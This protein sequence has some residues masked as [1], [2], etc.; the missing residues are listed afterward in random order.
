MKRWLRSNRGRLATVR[1]CIALTS[2]FVIG[3]L[4]SSAKCSALGISVNVV[5][6]VA[7]TVTSGRITA[8]NHQLIVS[9]STAEAPGGYHVTM[10]ANSTTL[11]NDDVAGARFES[12]ANQLANPGV[13]SVGTW[14]YA[15][16][17]RPG[18]DRNYVMN[19]ALSSVWA[20]VPLGREDPIM[21][22]VLP[23]DQGGLATGNVWFGIYSSN[24]QI[25]GKYSATV[26][27]TVVADVLEPP[28]VES[29]TP[30]A[31]NL[32][33]TAIANRVTITGQYLGT[34]NQVCVDLNRN[35]RCDSYSSGGLW[36]D[37]TLNEIG[38]QVGDLTNTSITFDLPNETDI[39]IGTYDIIVRT[40]ASGGGTNILQ[41]A[42]TYTRTP[43]LVSAT[44]QSF[45]LGG[46]SIM[47]MA[48]GEHHSIVLTKS[49]AVFTYGEDNSYGQLGTG[50]TTPH[51]T[52]TNITGSF[53]GKVVQIAALGDHSLVLTEDGRVYSWGDNEYGQVGNGTIGRSN[54]ALS[55]VDI[56]G[57]FNL[58]AGQKIIEIYA[59]W[60][61]S[62]ALTDN[63][64]VFAW[65]DNHS[66]QLATGDTEDKAVPTEVTF[67]FDGQMITLA[68]DSHVL[69]LTDTGH[70]YSWGYNDHGQADGTGE[71]PG[72]GEDMSVMRPIEITDKLELS[73]DVTIK[74]IGAGSN[75]SL[76]LLSDNSA[77]VWGQNDYGSLGTGGSQSYQ[78]LTH[79]TW[80]PGQEIDQFAAGYHSTIAL[81]ESG[82]IY[83][84]GRNETGQLGLGRNGNILSPTELTGLG[85]VSRVYATGNSLFAVD[86]AGPSYSWGY[87]SEPV[88][89]SGDINYRLMT[90]TGQNLGNATGA[91]IDLNN[92]GQEDNNEICADFTRVNSTKLTCSIPVDL[93]GINP[94]TY[95]INVV[96]SDGAQLELSQYFRYYRSQTGVFMNSAAALD[97]TVLSP[98]DDGGSLL[99]QPETV[100][101]IDESGQVIESN[102]SP[103]E[104]SS[105]SS[106]ATT[107]SGELSLMSKLQGFGH[108]I[109]LNNVGLFQ[110]GDSNGDS[111]NL[112]ITTG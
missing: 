22:S 54:D 76:V 106:R 94:G 12:T 11:D 65:G 2:S 74:S 111:H 39:D 40:S 103:D 42:F 100:E 47:A 62:F 26:T 61:S 41:D 10:H 80:L 3:S 16:P 110:V 49:G 89:V 70:L 57:N 55:P 66:G 68:T 73:S 63:G 79:V 35:G 75:S 92:N 108:M 38:V 21:E 30:N 112:K 95:D 64:R 86:D 88:D 37:D 45:D 52:P 13:L 83:V 33:N 1:V 56:T 97:N 36:G 59:A 46:D 60:D 78:P 5:P 48:G 31:Y 81:T 17:G 96:L 82:K 18:F 32:G 87:G 34:A 15:V 4:L 99:G 105:V 69:A 44:P 90:I 51:T 102:S 20:A 71:R 98:T 7:P 29:I 91:Y 72:A 8:I 101:V 53:V 107:Q 104:T 14:G 24:S 109:S 67:P 25:A 50:D 43:S 84:W 85:D 6:D 28:V 93:D 58:P 19:S 23:T 77:W 27:Y 9:A